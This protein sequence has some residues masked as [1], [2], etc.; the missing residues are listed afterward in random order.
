MPAAGRLR[1]Y[2][3]LVT[4]VAVV[5]VLT[6]FL[7]T[8]RRVAVAADPPAHDGYTQATDFKGVC[9][10]A[11]LAM[12]KQMNKIV[13]DQP[14]KGEEGFSDGS[15]PYALF[16]FATL[17]GTTI[18]KLTEAD[19]TNKDNAVALQ[20]AIKDA[21][22][23]G[24]AKT[25]PYMK[26]TDGAGNVLQLWCLTANTKHGGPDLAMLLIRK[27]QTPDKGVW[28]G[29]CVLPGGVN[30]W[31]YKA[32]KQGV[33]THFLWYNMA[34]NKNKKGT[35]IRI[36]YIYDVAKKQLAITREVVTLEKDGDK[37]K[38]VPD[39]KP[40]TENTPAEAPLNFEDLKL[41]GSQL[42][43]MLDGES[44]TPLRAAVATEVD[45]NSPDRIGLVNPPLLGSGTPDDP[46]VGNPITFEPGDN[47]VLRLPDGLALAGDGAN[48]LW[49][50]QPL[51]DSMVRLEYQGDVPFTLESGDLVDNV[52][53]TAPTPPSPDP[54]TL[55]PT[56]TDVPAPPVAPTTAAA[57]TLGEPSSSVGPTMT[58]TFDPSPA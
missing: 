23:A 6:A 28:I 33:L 31:W 45:P 53:A 56:P 49:T 22:A 14:K 2:R 58:P 38:I 35:Y 32:D 52:M 13:K 47:I 29:A 36:T 11:A 19:I 55:A 39:P 7:V 34:P 25:D 17:L 24:A 3:T 44:V 30:E 54:T 21:A 1:R 10:S 48:P 42:T 15:V 5:A 50:A 20:Q 9:N 26:G 40:E 57:P 37:F 8:P 51:G 18:E 41:N 43:T 4:F 27:G 12:A 16:L 46:Y